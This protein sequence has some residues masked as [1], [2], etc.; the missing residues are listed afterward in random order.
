MDLS[1]AVG[2]EQAVFR[3][4]AAFRGGWT[5]EAAE[6]VCDPD[7]Q[8]ETPVLDALDSLV[9]KSLVRSGREVTGEA[10]LFLLETIAEYAEERAEEAKE[11]GVVRERHR[12]YFSELASAPRLSSLGGSNVSG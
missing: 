6:A 12:R 5:M 10:R 1:T 3:R 4:L 9:E 2:D 8:L 7:F 11:A